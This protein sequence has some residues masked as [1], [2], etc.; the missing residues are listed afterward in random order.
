MK[1]L[2][3]RSLVIG[4]MIIALGWNAYGQAYHV[5]Q[6]TDNDYDECQA[7]ISNSSFVAWK[8]W[9]FC[10]GDTGEDYEI[11][12][13]NGTTTVQVTDNYNDEYTY[14]I[15]DNGN[16]VWD[17]SVTGVG[18]RIFLY[19]YDSKTINQIS[20]DHGSYNPHINN[21]DVVVWGGWDSEGPD[22]EILLYDGSSPINISDNSF[23]FRL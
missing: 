20:D 18:R 6:L 12:L 22:L 19:D 11:F 3:F 5:K 13:Y 10:N 14:A 15:N 16:I 21:N 8:G 23:F 2:L 7:C 9:G 17:Q 1:R 4:L